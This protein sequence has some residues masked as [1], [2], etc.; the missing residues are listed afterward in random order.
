MPEITHPVALTETKTRSQLRTYDH[1]SHEPIRKVLR[2]LITNIGFRWLAKVDKLIGLENVP[3]T[4]SAIL[5]INH[6]AFVDPI[7]VLGN[8]PRNIVPM[9]KAEASKIPIWGIFPGLW[10]AI[11]VHRGEADREALMRA[12]AVLAAGEIV[13]VAPEGTR[14]NAIED[15]KFGIAYLA[16]KSGAPVVPVAIEGTRGFPTI[17]PKR[18]AQGGA[19]VTF[20][21]PFR[22]KQFQGRLPRE[23]LKQMTDEAM[24]KVAE[25]LPDERRG[26]YSDLSK[27]TTEYL[28]SGDE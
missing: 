24:Y 7:V 18:W 27:A 14:H 3:T 17:S 5:M 26:I 21:K 25:I 13:L 16:Y 4:G 6:I 22:F 12:L 11:P 1:A 28:V 19:V 10:G 8:L 15:V 9:A 2:W 23:V 20:G